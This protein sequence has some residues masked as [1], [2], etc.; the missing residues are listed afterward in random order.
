MKRI[1]GLIAERYIVVGDRPLLTKQE[2]SLIGQ[3]YA[4]LWVGLTTR[5]GVE[6]VVRME[7]LPRLIDPAG[8]STKDRDPRYIGVGES[9]FRLKV[10]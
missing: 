10:A 9:I 7:A 8:A 5:I 2:V 6:D 4:G 1:V 3:T